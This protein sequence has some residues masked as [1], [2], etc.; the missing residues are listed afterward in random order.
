MGIL[1]NYNGVIVHDFLK[2]YYKY[3]CDHGLC[4]THLLRE[5]TSI[6]ENY[7]QEWSRQ[8]ADLLLVI[9]ECVDETREIVDAYFENKIQIKTTISTIFT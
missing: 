4:D 7:E 5:L 1:P 6:S 3:L 9:K 2:S 8:M